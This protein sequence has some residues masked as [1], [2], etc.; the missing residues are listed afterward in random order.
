MEKS[1]TI[2]K[3]HDSD[4]FVDLQKMQFVQVDNPANVISFNDVQDNG[5]HCLVMYDTLTRNAFQGTWSE[6]MQS[7]A[8][9]P[10]KLPAVKDLDPAGLAKVRHQGPEIN[11]AVLDAS[12]TLG[13]GAAQNK[14]NS[15]KKGT[16]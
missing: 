5:D 8:V 7:K 4:F 10:V 6:L 15:K 12:R 9:V 11:D 1:K 13:K 2:L 3:I 14:Q 16:R